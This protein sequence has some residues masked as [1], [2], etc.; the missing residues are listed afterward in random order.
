VSPLTDLY[1]CD[2]REHRAICAPLGNRIL[3]CFDR[4]HCRTDE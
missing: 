1:Q 3:G 4:E 2:E